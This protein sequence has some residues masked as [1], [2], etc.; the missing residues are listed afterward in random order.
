[1]SSIPFN[2]FARRKTQKQELTQTDLLESLVST[3]EPAVHKKKVHAPGEGQVITI[4]GIRIDFPLK[5]YAAQIQ[6]MTRIIHA[7]N[8]EENALLESPTGSGKSLALLCAALAWRE[9]QEKLRAA[10]I[11]KA[12][13]QQA[14]EKRQITDEPE[15]SQGPSKK[16]KTRLESAPSFC[17]DEDF[18]PPLVKRFI[19]EVVETDEEKSQSSTPDLASMDEVKRMKYET[20]KAVPRIFVGSRTHKQIT[21]LVAELKSNTRYSPRTTI[22]GSRDHLCVHPKV[23]KSNNK[24]DDCT[25]LLDENKCQYAHGTKRIL[26]H[27]SLRVENRIWDIEDMVHLGKKVR[28]C[29]YYAARKLYEGAEVIF[30]PY[31]YIIDPVI[32]KIL[33]INLKNS[34]VILDEAH[35]IEDASRSAGS[36]DVDEDSLEVLLKELKLTARF[37]GEKEAHNEMEVIIGGLYEAM[38]SEDI[39]YVVKEYE[40]QSCHFTGQELLD[41]LDDMN[42]TS[43]TFQ[44]N[45]LPAFNKISSHAEEVRKAKENKATQFDDYEMEEIDGLSSQVAYAQGTRA[46]S[47]GSLTVLQ[48]LITV[49]GFIFRPEEHNDKDYQL[50]FMKAMKRAT[51]NPNNRRRRFRDPAKQSLWVHKIAFWCLNPAIIFSDMC[52]DTRSVILTSGT[53]SPLNTFASELGV[54]FT[55]RLEANHVIKPSQVWVSSIPQGPNR[56]PLKCVYSNMESLAFQDEVGETLCDIIERVPYGVLVFMPSYKALDVFTSRWNNTGVMDRL[57]DK[58]L[59]LSEPK[60]SDKKEFEGVL[61]T[62]YDQIDAVEANID[63]ENRDGALFFAVFRGKVS[64]GIDFS[65]NYCRAVVTLGIPFPGFKDLEVNLKRDYNNRMKLQSNGEN[66]LSGTEWY[67]AQAYRGIGKMHQTQNDWGAII[68]LEERFNKTGI[69]NNLSKWVKGQYKQAASYRDSIAN[70]EQF[71][72]RQVEE[73]KKKAEEERERRRLED[74]RAIKIESQSFT[75]DTDP[76][77]VHSSQSFEEKII[78]IKEESEDAHAAAMDK[79]DEEQPATST[80]S[81][82]FNQDYQKTIPLQSIENTYDPL[83][84]PMSPSSPTSATSKSESTLLVYSVKEEEHDVEVD[85]D[86]QIDLPED[87]IVETPEH[88]FKPDDHDLMPPPR[89]PFVKHEPQ[90]AFRDSPLKDIH[91]SANE[92]NSVYLACPKCKRRLLQ[93]SQQD[94]QLGEVLD[95]ESVRDYTGSQ[96]IVQE[97]RNPSCWEAA[98]ELLGGPLDIRSLPSRGS[99]VYD[100]G[101]GVCFRFLSCAC[102]S[103]TELGMVVCLAANPAKMHHVGKVYL[104]GFQTDEQ[105]S[106]LKG[107]LLTSDDLNAEI[108]NSQYSSA[109]DHFYNL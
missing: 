50:V 11:L 78:A 34:I 98:A 108:P 62:Y 88:D 32:R 49:L 13:Q 2:Y 15:T 35:N 85:N 45:I 44:D 83:D 38:K 17:S 27:P 3:A 68:L 65:D 73:D 69:V 33:D 74:E 97:I 104:W 12:Q 60:G 31:N 102:D 105:S 93:G 82:Y 26:N 94:L 5:P 58:K 79:Q 22:L 6:M 1:M 101:D 29:P 72:H 81:K 76:H 92:A 25:T 24:A 109:N 20:Y 64:E 84:D 103:L 89:L 57:K 91:S 4:E 54:P 70:L 80:F 59:V 95:L 37:G 10:R 18:Q 99:V 71:I 100:K 7:L 66:L 8:T 63:E 46:V 52:K 47:N 55:G 67:E 86:F 21:Q 42:I 28:G 19:A 75:A 43:N 53:L 40:R 9:N 90:D 77:I 61:N 41:K 56:I 51:A 87:D 36:L 23:S 106:P 16:V 14:P 30:C 107:A 39:D 96:C 48:G